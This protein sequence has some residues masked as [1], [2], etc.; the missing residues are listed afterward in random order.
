MPKL[1]VLDTETT[2]LSDPIQVVELAYLEVD[3]QLAVLNEISSF[4]RP[5][6]EIEPGA[7]KVH[8]ISDA[9]VADAPELSDVLAPLAQEEVIVMGHNIQFDLRLVS[10]HLK[11]VGQLCTLA[12]ARQFITDSVNCKLST[13]QAH[14]N[15]PN[16]EAHRALGDAFTALN[17]LRWMLVRYGLTLQTHIKRQELPRMLHVMP[18]GKH[19]GKLITQVPKL[20]RQWLLGA[21]NLDQDLRYTLKRLENL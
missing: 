15:L 18:Y 19:K 3:D 6:R 5:S 2:G 14:C 9:D 21:G 1:I 4:V 7:F 10:H 17:L 11:V 12:L 16:L 13:L 8:G 20:Y